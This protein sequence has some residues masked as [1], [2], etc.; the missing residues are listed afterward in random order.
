MKKRNYNLLK[1]H[2]I[3]ELLALGYNKAGIMY[4]L[5]IAGG[6]YD[7]YQAEIYKE[8]GVCDCDKHHSKRALALIKILE[9]NQNMGVKANKTITFTK[10][11]DDLI[12]LYNVLKRNVEVLERVEK[13]LKERNDI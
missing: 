8:L 3:K 4:L 1:I 6:T 9:Q 11:N 12:D 10:P 2:R 7:M 13:L 5:A